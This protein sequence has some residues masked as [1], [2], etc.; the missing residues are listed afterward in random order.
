MNKEQNSDNPQSQQLNI[1][2]VR[3]R[4][5]LWWKSLGDDIGEIADKYY[6]GCETIQEHQIEE[7]YH[8]EHS[9]FKQSCYSKK[10]V[11]NVSSICKCSTV[12]SVCQS[13]VA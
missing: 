10:C 13:H 9:L 12:G 1:A 11:Y 6:R 7:I 3:Q 4:A 5:L 2:G 8:K